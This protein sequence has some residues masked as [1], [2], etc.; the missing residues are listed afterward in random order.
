[1]LRSELQKMISLHE[2]LL[3]RA[4]KMLNERYEELEER[5]EVI[6]WLEEY[7]K[8]QRILDWLNEQQPDEE[9]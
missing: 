3:Q 4:T 6:E 2:S 7:L 9:L 1:M 5:N 8:Q